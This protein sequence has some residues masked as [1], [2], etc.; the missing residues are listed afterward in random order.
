M[1]QNVLYVCRP[2]SEQ[3]L[4]LLSVVSLHLPHVLQ[5]LARSNKDYGGDYCSCISLTSTIMVPK[6]PFTKTAAGGFTPKNYAASARTLIWQPSKHWRSFFFLFLWQNALWLEG[7]RHHT[8][9]RLTLWRQANTS[10]THSTFISKGWLHWRWPQSIMLHW[11]VT[12][13]RIQTTPSPDKLRQQRQR[14]LPF[15]PAQ[16]SWEY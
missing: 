5:K 2:P 15:T 14:I 9:R 8:A 3:A 11:L 4:R 6:A 7:S 12:L 13:A 1:L 16:V 10:N